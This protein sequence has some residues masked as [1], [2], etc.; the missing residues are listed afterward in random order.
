MLTRMS[1]SVPRRQERG[2]RR[3]EQI[4]DAATEVFADVG[5]ERATTNAI[6]ARAGI[7]P[8]SL[9]QYFADKTAIA[10][11]LWERYRR[12]L[13]EAEREPSVDLSSVPLE[14]LADL[15][16]DPVFAV[17]RRYS[18]FATLLA[19]AGSSAAIE[20]VER[21]HMATEARL[22]ELLAARNPDAPSES[23]QRVV[24]MVVA[25]FRSAAAAESVTGDA[26]GD[27]DELKTAI[28][29]YLRAR[30]LT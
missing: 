27:L 2:L 20:A 19:K 10:T 29:A 17:K 4:L 21:S 12:A 5:Y 7:S 18:A 1:D 16:V 8:G 15:L 25:M 13:E 9:Y 23:L 22:V 30:G 14:R 11:A 26:A 24:A 28:V 6:A 3:I